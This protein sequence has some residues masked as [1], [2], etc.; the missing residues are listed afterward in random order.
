MSSSHSPRSLQDR[1]LPWG[2]CP[3]S[4][5]HLAATLTHPT[6]RA[7]SEPGCPPDLGSA[8]DHRGMVCPEPC[9]GRPCSD[10][11]PQQSLVGAGAELGLLWH[12]KPGWRGNTVLQALGFVLL[13][14]FKP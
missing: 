4:M 14:F 2:C 12:W 5:P 3:L 7:P 8:S 11:I 6:A 10:P 9:S 1:D 13:L